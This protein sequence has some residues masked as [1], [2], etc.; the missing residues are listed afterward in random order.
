V[1]R[2][3]TQTALA[4]AVGVSKQLM[5]AVSLGQANFSPE[6]LA[7]VADV[8]GCEVADLLPADEGRSRVRQ[9][10]GLVAAGSVLIEPG[11]LGDVAEVLGCELTDL[12]PED[13]SDLA[14][15]LGCTIDDLLPTPLATHSRDGAR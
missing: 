8:L 12:A 3:L 6:T 15:A 11:H 14:D 10:A 9:L 5:S 1:E 4:N 2:G 7:K 13:L